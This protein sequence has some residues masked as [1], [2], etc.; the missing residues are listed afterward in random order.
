[1][2]LLYPTLWQQDA[3][4]YRALCY[5]A[6]NVAALR[7]QQLPKKMKRKKN[8]AIITD[9]DET[10]L[11]NSYFQAQLIKNNTSYSDAFWKQWVSKSAAT[12]VPGAVEFLQMASHKGIHVFYI[13][14]RD[15]SGV[16]ATLVNLKQYSFPDADTAH[17]LFKSNTSSKE[18]RR[19]TVMQK[20]N[21][22]MLLGDNLAD[23]TS[24]FEGRGIDDRFAETD[25][26][27]EDWGKRFIVLPNPVYGD[28]EAAFYDYQRPLTE[29]QK[30]ALL[31][32]LLK[33][34]MP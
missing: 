5:Q 27:K 31:L 14:N 17:L 2:R 29:A 13:S 20:Y 30:E 12:T 3:A 7:I 26:A 32:K 15:T 4:E 23:F 16:A 6:Y 10:V 9:I 21:V 28:W 25:K 1:M 11:D 19:G 33:G 8:L 34:F 22:V 18:N 24:L